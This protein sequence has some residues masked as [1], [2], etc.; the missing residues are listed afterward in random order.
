MH[1]AAVYAVRALQAGGNGYIRKQ[2][3]P[4]ELIHAIR[5]VLDGRIYVSKDMH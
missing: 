3:N 4:E 2:G 5:Q 1:D